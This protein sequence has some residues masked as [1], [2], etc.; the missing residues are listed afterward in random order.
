M[1]FDSFAATKRYPN[2]ILSG[3]VH[4]YQRFTKVTQ[5]P[6][7][8]LQIPCIVA[9]AGGYINLGNLHTVNGAPPKA[10]LLLTNGLTLAGYDQTNFGFLRLE[11]TKRQIAGTYFSAP[12]VSGGTPAAKVGDNFVID[13][14]K[15]TVTTGG[16]GGKPGPT[17]PGK[18]PKS[19]K[20][21]GR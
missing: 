5:G 8:S 4:N 14:V 15:N 10:P 12:F 21:K 11:V 18:K 7:G 3:H 1:L 6:N 13:L 9:G 19:P 20:K 17:K 2:L 16:A